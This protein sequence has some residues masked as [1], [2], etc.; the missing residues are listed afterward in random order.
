MTDNSDNDRRPQTPLDTFGAV[1]KDIKNRTLRRQAKALLEED[2]NL[3]LDEIALKLNVPHGTLQTAF[4]QRSEPTKN[5]NNIWNLIGGSALGV[6]ALSLFNNPD[7]IMNFIN[8]KVTDKPIIAGLLGGGLF[9]VKKFM[10]W[11]EERKTKFI[12]SIIPFLPLLSPLALVV[13]LAL[14]VLF[15]G[16]LLK[17]KWLEFIHAFGG[18]MEDFTEDL[19]E[20]GAE[21]LDIDIEERKDELKE[22][23]GAVFHFDPTDARDQCLASVAS[24]Y[25]SNVIKMGLDKKSGKF[26]RKVD[27]CVEERLL[28]A[29]A[30]DK[31]KTKCEEIGGTWDQNTGKCTPP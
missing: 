3:T 26:N 19:I 27:A 20:T 31:A 25:G 11:S 18:N 15:V 16:S 17:G 9:F 29:K 23:I 10:S 13:G 7:K 22:D 4:D 28:I 12:D 5:K 6:G 24:S 2:F 14:L 1:K 21:I 8:S 30:K